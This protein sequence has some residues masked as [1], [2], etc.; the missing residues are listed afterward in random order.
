MIQQHFFDNLKIL[1]GNF[2]SFWGTKAL[3]QHYYTL[4]LLKKVKS[5]YKIIL[6]TLRFGFASAFPY[7]LK[8]DRKQGKHF[9]VYIYFPC[10]KLN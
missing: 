7:I 3:C 8:P 2:P 5:F 6:A 10:K 1:L 9:N 4:L